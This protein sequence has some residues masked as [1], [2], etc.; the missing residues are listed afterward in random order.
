MTD[1]IEPPIIATKPYHDRY[2]GVATYQPGDHHVGNLILVAHRQA[3]EDLAMAAQFQ[4]AGLSS[5]TSTHWLGA[6]AD[7]D[8]GEDYMR[9]VDRVLRADLDP[10]L[11]TARSLDMLVI[12]QG[13]GTLEE[14]ILKDRKERFH[15]KGLNPELYNFGKNMLAVIEAKRPPRAS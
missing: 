11:A 15:L 1:E 9:K 6:R 8:L 3:F 13:A 2:K 10:L 12:T 14:Q 5:A 7:V 4:E